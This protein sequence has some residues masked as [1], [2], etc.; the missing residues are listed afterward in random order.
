MIAPKVSVIVPVYDVSQYLKEC[1]DSIINQS[2][3]DIEIIVVDDKSPDPLDD[4]ICRDYEDK[5]RRVVYVEHDKN[6]GL[7]GARNT[8]IK[9]SKGKYIGFVDS[10]DILPP[11]SLSTMLDISETHDSDIVVGIIE[12][13][14]EHDDWIGVPVHRDHFTKVRINTNISL[15][16]DL[17]GDVSS[18]NKLFR[19][20]LIENNSLRFP[21]GTSAEDQ[22]FVARCYLL[23]KNISIVPD[24]VYRY[25][26]RSS[27]ITRRMDVSSFIEK[28]N[29]T[30]K[31]EVFFSSHDHLYLY[32]F[33][34]RSQ[35]KKLVGARFTKVV[36]DL[37]Y[38]D[39]RSVFNIIKDLID[40]LGIEEISEN[41][42]FTP[43]E[44][45]RIIM[46]RGCE[47]DSLIA[48]EQNPFD[49]RFLPL[50]SH[51]IKMKGSLLEPLLRI[52]QTRVGPYGMMGF[53]PV[54]RPL[55]S[56]TVLQ[57]FRSFYL[58]FA[59]GPSRAF[60]RYIILLPFVKLLSPLL[61]GKDVWLMDERVCRSAEDNGYF[62]F[63]YL[64]QHYPDLKVYFVI[65]SGSPDYDKV[66]K[67]GQVVVHYSFSH[68]Y[69]LLQA[70]VLLSTDSFRELT[71]PYEIAPGL[72]RPT[73]NVF[74]KHGVLGNKFTHYSKSNFPHISQITASSDLEKTQIYINSYGFDP[75]QISV[76]GLA[77]FDNLFSNDRRQP[78]NHILIVPT[79]RQWLENVDDID[80]SK[81]LWSWRDLIASEGLGRLLD[82][83]NIEATFIP[84]FKM[85]R[86]LTDFCTE[87][88]RIN[89]I[90]D[91][92]SPLYEYIMEC[93]LL[94]T[95]YSSL[96]YDFLYQN[97]PVIAYMFDKNEWE[98]Q[99][100]APPHI[101]FDKDL[102]CEI[103]QTSSGV[104]DLLEWY[105]DNN[106]LLKE[107]HK[108]KADKFFEYRDSRNCE[109][110]YDSICELRNTQTGPQHFPGLTTRDRDV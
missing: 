57:R 88:S 108:V 91:L 11:D 52:Y 22:D 73:H 28:V 20:S 38:D 77:R 79:W 16:P 37:Q 83:H 30:K 97:K 85:S 7:G 1:L 34:L 90:D 110:I 45:I 72:R 47:F 21:E 40:L 26:G 76:T 17:L 104:V 54:D 42:Y 62:F 18:C 94:V 43:L 53:L 105:I 9:I 33:L 89:I 98:K 5:D 69:Y 35:V 101:D 64:R 51:N 36:K 106:F 48:F 99:P 32:H 109:R 50:L 87:C 4:A 12:S 13:F 58:R 102:P 63:K 68:A 78:S 66:S 96:M 86:F 24:I 29:I 8:G 31:L 56:G 80:P 84:H 70:N 95:D 59:R 44:Q 65:S 46:L 39:Q 3:S 60:L 74:L 92:G 27:S 93:D 55:P 81:F 2:L 67:L 15:F 41:G 100:P 23:A 49:Y 75:V 107:E 71:Y 10:D 14:N 6:L 25:R 19:R 103:E 61:S 82:K